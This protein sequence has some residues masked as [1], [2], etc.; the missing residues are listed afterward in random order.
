MY[1]K[2]TNERTSQPAFQSHHSNALDA[3]PPS[4]PTRKE[5]FFSDLREA[6]G[7]RTGAAA[8]LVV[9]S[10]KTAGGRPWPRSILLPGWEAG[11]DMRWSRTGRSAEAVSHGAC[12]G[13][14]L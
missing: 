9:P 6:E 3:E 11:R 12:C 14:R 13:L 1:D 2:P 5:R 7:G 4:Q 8:T 10:I